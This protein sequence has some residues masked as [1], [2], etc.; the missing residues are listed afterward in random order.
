MVGGSEDKGHAPRQPTLLLPSSSSAGHLT[1][2]ILV[3]NFIV[4]ALGTGRE[5]GVIFR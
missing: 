1:K 5:W 3:P 4:L 2:K